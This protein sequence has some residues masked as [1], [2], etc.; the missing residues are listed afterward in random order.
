[1][2]NKGK[3]NIVTVE[4]SKIKKMKNKKNIILKRKSVTCYSKNVVKPYKH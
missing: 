1:M 2:L 3:C 4:I